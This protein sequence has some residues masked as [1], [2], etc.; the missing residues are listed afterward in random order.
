MDELRRSTEAARLESDATAT[1]PGSTGVS[2]SLDGDS[3]QVFDEQLFQFLGRKFAESQLFFPVFRLQICGISGFSSFLTRNL[4]KIGFFCFFT[5]IVL[6]IG[7]FQF[8]NEILLKDSFF[9]AFWLKTSWKSL[10]SSFLSGNLLKSNV[11]G[12][13]LIKLGVSDLF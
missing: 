1:I 4:L 12:F 8:L 6:K 3:E 2:T 10:F 5:G 7:F 11:L 9:P 13:Q